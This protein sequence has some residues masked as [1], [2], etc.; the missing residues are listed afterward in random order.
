[1]VDSYIVLATG[2]SG[3][4]ID[5]TMMIGYFILMILIMY[6][7]LI[8]PQQRK[9]KERRALLASVKSG[10]RVLFGG[11]ILGTVTNVKEK[12][13]TIRVAEKTKIEVARGAVTQVLAKDEEPADPMGAR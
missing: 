12:I 3:Q 4:P 10:D 1:M 2:G 11:G 13:L 6:F 5:G 9:E 8:R 7:I